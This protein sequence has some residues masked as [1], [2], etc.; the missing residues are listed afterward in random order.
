MSFNIP[1]W[2]KWASYITEIYLEETSSVHN[3][4]LLV[5]LVNGRLMLS[6]NN[7]IYS[8]GDKYHNF[9]YSFKKMDLTGVKEVLLLGVGLGSI[10]ILLEKKEKQKFSYTGVEIDEEVMY[11]ASKYVIPGLSSDFDLVTSDAISFLSIDTRKYDMIAMD[12]FESDYI[13]SKFETEEYLES[14]KNHLTENGI[15]MYNR[16]ACTEKDINKSNKFYRDVFHKV[17]PQATTLRI[18]GNLMLFNR[19]DVLK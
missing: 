17:F 11:L 7:A 2:K 15:L 9:G 3:D 19:S 1:K 18:K 10:P 12:I 16:L 5:S 13:P 6:T 4:H 8:Y 14:L